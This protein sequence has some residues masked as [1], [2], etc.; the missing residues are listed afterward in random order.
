MKLPINKILNG[1]ALSELK[2]IPNESIN[3]IMTSPPYLALRDYGNIT[4]QIW[5]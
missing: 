5:D 2:K 4:E 3:C 1:D